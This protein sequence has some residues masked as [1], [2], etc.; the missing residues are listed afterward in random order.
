MAEKLCETQHLSNDDTR[1][2]ADAND[3]SERPAESHRGD[4]GHEDRDGVSSNAYR[5][6]LHLMNLKVL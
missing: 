6:G 1:E 3:L 4:L 5:A 2:T